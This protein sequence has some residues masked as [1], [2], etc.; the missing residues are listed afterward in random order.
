[1][2]RC[3]YGLFKDA[4]SSSHYIAL[5]VKLENVWTEGGTKSVVVTWNLAVRTKRK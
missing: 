5:N 2:T 4:V 3:V 1:V